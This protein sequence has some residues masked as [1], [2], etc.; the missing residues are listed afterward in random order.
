MVATFYRRLDGRDK[1]AIF[2]TLHPDVVIHFPDRQVV[3][4][5]GYWAY[6]SQVALL[7]PDYAHEL[8]GVEADEQ[9]PSMVQVKRMEISGSLANGEQLTLPGSARYRVVEGRIVEAWIGIG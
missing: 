8:Q 2:D 1:N 9:D 6:V 3:G 7:I 4:A 5:A